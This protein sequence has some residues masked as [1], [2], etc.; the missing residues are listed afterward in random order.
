MAKAKSSALVRSS[1]REPETS[2]ALKDHVPGALRQFISAATEGH[3][4]Q[5]DINDTEA[6]W[7]FAISR[8]HRQVAEKILSGFAF[9]I[10]RQRTPRG[11]FI[12]RLKSSQIAISSAYED[13]DAYELFA[14]IPTSETITAIAKLGPTR[15]LA[16]RKVDNE[17]LAALAKGDEISGMDLETLADLPANEVRALARQGLFTRDAEIKGLK[18]EIETLRTAKESAEALAAQNAEIAAQGRQLAPNYP[19]FCATVREESAVQA[20]IIEQAIDLLSATLD[21]HL[22]AQRAERAGDV[23]FERYANLAASTLY[24]TLLAKHARMGALLQQVSEEFGLPVTEADAATFA[25]TPAEVNA[26]DETCRQVL[27]LNQIKHKQRH[28]DREN[29]R[30]G[31]RGRTLKNVVDKS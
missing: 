11:E 16:L 21:E 1:S 5:L 9:S 24:H 29:N 22:M 27:G 30:P 19:H 6:L 18:A 28:I 17:S 13:I 20:S 15:Y 31:R 26:L 23:E 4:P 10:L 8:V 2:G 25:L 14:R 3:L 7:N 12:D